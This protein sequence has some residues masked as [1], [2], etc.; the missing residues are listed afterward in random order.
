MSHDYYRCEVIFGGAS[1][2]A[3][4]VESGDAADYGPT[5]P[6][7]FSWSRPDPGY[8]AAPDHIVCS[9]G[10]ILA[11]PAEAY[12]LN[13]GDPVEVRVWFEPGP[14]SPADCPFSFYGRVGE[15]VAEPHGLGMF[16]PVSCVG[17]TV[18][19][20]EVDSGRSDY[21]LDSPQERVEAILIDC[22]LTIA[23][24]LAPGGI[25]PDPGSPGEFVARPASKTGA[26]DLLQATLRQSLFNRP[27]GQLASGVIHP[28]IAF[29][30]P[31]W[32]LDYLDARHYTE[33]APMPALLE[34]DAGSGFYALTLTPDPDTGVVDGGLIETDSARWR[35]AKQDRTT[36]EV[37]TGW[38]NFPLEQTL[39]ETR[40]RRPADRIIESSESVDVTYPG[41][42][43][44]RWLPELVDA[45]GW[46]ADSFRFR[47]SADPDALPPA[48][49]NGYAYATAEDKNEHALLYSRPWAIANIPHVH[50]PSDGY[51]AGQLLGAELVIDTE[52]GN[53]RVWVD[54]RLSRT[55]PRPV[56]Y[57]AGD[58]EPAPLGYLSWADIPAGCDWADLDPALSWYELRLARDS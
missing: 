13:E 20:A 29:G 6:L 38:W 53:A 18:D 12:G 55:I 30:Y 2:L 3:Y 16:Y 52:G 26:W 10:L 14:G 25:E 46:Q 28:S 51:V 9:F 34:L 11:D 40:T 17:Y 21:G 8:P 35:R 23:L 41:L 45:Q 5:L 4:D 56:P 31:T 19:I 42:L 22:G 49:Y 15:L 7:R 33:N 39:V 32:N 57:V 58:Y 44:E 54:F 24:G 1:G 50:N 43:A 37:V 47:L 48:F 36:D 27:G